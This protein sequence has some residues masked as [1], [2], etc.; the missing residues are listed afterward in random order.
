MFPREGLEMTSQLGVT[1]RKVEDVSF[2][3]RFAIHTTVPIGSAYQITSMTLFCESVWK[4]SSKMSL[5]ELRV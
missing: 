3:Y 2:A 5:G 1:A 4:P